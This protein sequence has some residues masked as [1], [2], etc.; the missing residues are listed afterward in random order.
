MGMFDK[1]MS[2]K[3]SPKGFC[4]IPNG[5]RGG[6]VFKFFVACYLNPYSPTINSIIRYAQEILKPRML[7]SSNI[8]SNK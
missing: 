5:Y 4:V 7:R 1:L 3:S 6:I 8:F 2:F